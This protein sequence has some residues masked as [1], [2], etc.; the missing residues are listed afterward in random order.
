M[1]QTS[2]AGAGNFYESHLYRTLQDNECFEFE[3]L[4]HTTNVQNYPEG[5]VTEVDKAPVWQSLDAIVNSVT[6]KE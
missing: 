5:T 4:I 6:F 1:A 3:Q 2:D